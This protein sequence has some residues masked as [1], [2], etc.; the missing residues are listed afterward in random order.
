MIAEVQ[1]V[2]QTSSLT[3]LTYFIFECDMRHSSYMAFYV[4]DRIPGANQESHHGLPSIVQLGIYPK[5][6]ANYDE[7]YKT[8]GV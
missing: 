6:Q 4:I 7:G 8:L 2:S 1:T 5:G 3:K